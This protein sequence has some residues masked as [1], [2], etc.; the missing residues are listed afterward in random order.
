MG[1]PGHEMGVMMGSGANH[2][3]ATEYT[4]QG[5]CRPHKDSIA[6]IERQE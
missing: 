4:L 6:Q 2:P 3:P 1:G 5:Q